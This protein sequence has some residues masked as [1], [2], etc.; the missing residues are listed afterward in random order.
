MN[1]TEPKDH[2]LVHT[3]YLNITS[4]KVFRGSH[5]PDA[6]ELVLAEAFEYEPN[7]FYVLKLANDVKPAAYIL[8][9][10]KSYTT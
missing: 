3:K 8:A 9:F 5:K 2:F 1:L 6:K 7:E 10:G 4:A